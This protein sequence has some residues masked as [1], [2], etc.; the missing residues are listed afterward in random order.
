MVSTQHLG[1]WLARTAIWWGVVAAAVWG[2]TRLLPEERFDDGI[3][4]RGGGGLKVAVDDAPPPHFLAVTL[5]WATRW[6]DW[7]DCG[8]LPSPEEVEAER[9]PLFGRWAEPLGVWVR[10]GREYDGAIGGSTTSYCTARTFAEF[11]C[12][13]WWPAAGVAALVW[14]RRR[15]V[16]RAF[17]PPRP[18]E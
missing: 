3:F 11:S 9:E 7:S 12:T 1:V 15:A 5:G 18:A 13:P 17:T 2:G 10:W 16:R 6:A 4:S 14:L 8:Y